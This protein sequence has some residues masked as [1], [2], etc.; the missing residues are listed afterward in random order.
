MGT[1]QN[2]AALYLRKSSLDD[3][4]GIEPVSTTLRAPEAVHAAWN[5]A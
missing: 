4:T 5:P 1:I 2:T 3:P